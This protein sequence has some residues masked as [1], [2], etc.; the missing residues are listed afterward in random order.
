M[1]TA[2]QR[3]III[4]YSNSKRT[5]ATR[6]H[7][8]ST[9]RST[10]R[11]SV[12]RVKSCARRKSAIGNS[13]VALPRIFAETISPTRRAE[14]RAPC[15]DRTSALLSPRS[16]SKTICTSLHR[17]RKRRLI[18]VHQ[19]WPPCLYR[20]KTGGQHL[21]KYCLSAISVS[22]STH[23]S[24]LIPCTHDLFLVLSGYLLELFSFP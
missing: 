18:R 14:A 9:M 11:K 12:S 8:K 22:L 5:L 2:H 23:H 10:T 19:R 21:S 4:S 24:R 13:L 15:R 6:V 3:T 17:K 20:N 16:L 7:I 1:R